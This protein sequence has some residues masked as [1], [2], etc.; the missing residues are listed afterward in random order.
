MFPAGHQ[1]EVEVVLVVELAL[2]VEV[3]DALALVSVLVLLLV[4]EPEFIVKVSVS[5]PML[6]VYGV[7]A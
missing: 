7:P 1:P 6:T 2:V 3:V 5:L 4:V